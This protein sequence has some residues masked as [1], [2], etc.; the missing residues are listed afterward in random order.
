MNAPAARVGP[1]PPYML[2]AYAKPYMPESFFTA[3]GLKKVTTILANQKNFTT[4]EGTPANESAFTGCLLGIGMALRD[5]YRCHFCEEGEMTHPSYVASAPH[6]IADAEPL[7]QICD[8]ITALLQ[9]RSR[10]V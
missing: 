1:M 7:L 4:K 9:N 10:S 5:I 6:S 8:D 2:W 3:A